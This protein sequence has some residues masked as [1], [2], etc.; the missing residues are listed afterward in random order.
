MHGEKRYMKSHTF[1]Q[2]L[3]EYLDLRLGYWRSRHTF[4]TKDAKRILNS[5]VLVEIK[6]GKWAT[7]NSSKKIADESQP[8]K[9]F[10][11]N[12]QNRRGFCQDLRL[13]WRIPPWFPMSYTNISKPQRSRF[14]TDRKC[15]TTKWNRIRYIGLTDENE[16]D[17]TRCGRI[18]SVLLNP[19]VFISF[20]IYNNAVGA[21]LEIDI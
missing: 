17:F 3:T 13:A 21:E 12:V 5:T 19:H 20:R 6:S 18:C 2:W 9:T 15:T 8:R 4:Y 10:G 11:N 16:T 1:L 7:I 14:T